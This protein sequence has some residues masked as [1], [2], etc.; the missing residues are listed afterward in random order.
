MENGA[1]DAGGGSRRVPTTTAVSPPPPPTPAAPSFSQ[2]SGNWQINLSCFCFHEEDDDDDMDRKRVSRTHVQRSN[3]QKLTEWCANE[4]ERQILLWV[5]LLDEAVMQ[6][7]E[8][9][10]R[11]VQ[12]GRFCEGNSSTMV[13]QLMSHEADVYDNEGVFSTR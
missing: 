7:S 5:G 11:V 8:A 4:N 2:V 1:G 13:P 12:F 10:G 3:D 9:H 6:S